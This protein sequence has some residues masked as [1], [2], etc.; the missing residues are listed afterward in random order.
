MVAKVVACSCMDARVASFRTVI[1]AG[2]TSTQVLAEHYRVSFHPSPTPAPECLISLAMDYQIAQKVRASTD[3][4]DHPNTSMTV[5]WDAADLLLLRNL[6]HDT[7]DPSSAAIKAATLDIFAARAA[8]AETLGGETASVAGPANR[9]PHWME[10]F[11]KAST[12]RVDRPRSVS[13][14]MVLHVI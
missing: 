13:L 2:D 9:L 8:E 1:D 3:P 14:A 5:P 12:R 6:S 7:G 10:S 11:D 4:H